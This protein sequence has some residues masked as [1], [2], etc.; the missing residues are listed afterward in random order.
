MAQTNKHD[1]NFDWAQKHSADKEA[2]LLAIIQENS[3]LPEKEQ[4]R[5]QELWRKCENETLSEDELTEYQ[6]LLSQLE[7][8]NLKRIEA[9]IT[10]AQEREK[11]LGEVTA[12]LG[13]KEGIN[14]F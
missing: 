8:R 6:A 2:L 3:Q 11:T 4:E 5:Y 7:A 10:L 14:A 9:L 12:E 13:L 1:S